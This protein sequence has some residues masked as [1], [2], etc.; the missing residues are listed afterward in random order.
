[1]SNVFVRCANYNVSCVTCCRSFELGTADSISGVIDK[2]CERCGKLLCPACSWRR[3]CV[4]CEEIIRHTPDELDAKIASIPRA[5]HMRVNGKLW[6][7]E[8]VRPPSRCGTVV[9]TRRCQC[10]PSG[11]KYIITS[12][13]GQT[14]LVDSCGKDFREVSDDMTRHI[15]LKGW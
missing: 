11:G 10:I 5:F 4:E 12:L 7:V 13:G 9:G 2:K 3:V 15:S 6:S 1:M 8:M 14:S